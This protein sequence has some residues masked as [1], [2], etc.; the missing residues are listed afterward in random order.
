MREQALERHLLALGLMTERAPGGLG[1]VQAQLTRWSVGWESG[2]A[3]GRT[4]AAQLLLEAARCSSHELL[5]RDLLLLG[6]PLEL[7]PAEAAEPQP[8]CGGGDAA[9]VAR[10][11]A[12]RVNVR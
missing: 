4:A 9:I 3:Q 2:H 10:P 7:G 5:E 8:D 12:P 6:P 1:E 11:R